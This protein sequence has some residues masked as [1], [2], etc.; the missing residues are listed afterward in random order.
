MKAVKRLFDFPY[1]QLENYPLKDALVTKYNGQWKSLSTKDYIAQANAL[2]RGLI[3]L[4][5]KPNDKIAVIS[6][7]NRTE[8]NIVD[9][10]VMQVGAQNVPIYPTISE[11]DYAYVLNH[12]ESTYCFVSDDEVLQKVLKIKDDVKSLKAVYTFD[13]VKSA[14]NW[15]AVLDQG[16]DESLQ[17]EVQKRMEAV[18]EKDLATLIYT[19]GTTGRP[20]GVMLSHKNI[21]SNAINSATRLPLDYGTAKA[22]SFLPVCHV[23][24]RM[25]QYM[26]Q[27]SGVSIYF[28]ESL[29]TISDNLKEV[30]PDVMSAVPRL[31]EKVYDKIIAK[32]ADLTEIKKALFF[33]AVKLGLKYKP[34]KA[35]GWWYE[36]KLGL[37]RKLIFSKWQEAL[38]GNLKVIA[39]GSAA[40]QPRLARVFNAANIKVMEGYGLT[41]T[42]PVVA[43]NDERDRGFKIG[44]VGKPISDTEVKIADDGEILVKGPQVMMGYYKDQ[45]KTDEVLKN[46]YFHTGDIGEIDAEGFLKITDRKKEMFK[47]SGGKYI[48]PQIIENKMKQ[49]RFIEQIMVV[50]EGQRMPAAFIQPNFEFL[51][52]WAHRKEVDFKDRTDLV[53]NQQVIDRYQEEVDFYNQSFGKWEKIK[54]FELTAEEWSIDK[55]HLTPTM[56][57]K[58]REIKAF[59]KD[60][61][62]KIYGP[63]S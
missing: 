11:E 60:L 34:Y 59:Y 44:T 49:S 55:G 40:L 54:R 6:T 36:K 31:L 43:V 30:K 15:K 48:A 14:Q 42:S 4:D 28:A 20:K 57:L 45:E 18:S 38:G 63:Q 47:T 13:G 52:E 50:G 24:E 33:W 35:N 5:V 21:T 22:L 62:E 19:S 8:W 2:S 53:N 32:G 12:S 26:Y 16:Q 29:E 39:S 27:Y 46:G 56:K 25:L 10:G 51:E 1:Y 61:F 17:D 3:K 9:I 7:N 41:E 23:Y 58:R 37:A